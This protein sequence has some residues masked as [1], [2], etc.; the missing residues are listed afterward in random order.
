MSPRTFTDTRLQARRRLGT[1]LASAALALGAFTVSASTAWAAGEHAHGQESH[2]LE[3]NA[4]KKWATD[5]PLRQGM[6][7]LRNAVAAKLP[8]VHS[9]KMSSAQ[10]DALGGQIDTQIAYIVQNCKLDPKAD[11]TLH[12]ILAG[13]TEGTEILRG[14]KPAHKRSEG[15]LKV[16][17]SL[18]Q[19]GGHF[20]HPGWTLP[21]AAH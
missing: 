2:A 18:E 20:D 16:V 8:A 9:G 15:V 14:K 3:L 5:D 4:G 7:R 13:L 17:H 6:T 10:Y 12:V 21:A 11:A 1:V 19:Y